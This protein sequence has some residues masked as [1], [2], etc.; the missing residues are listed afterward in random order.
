MTYFDWLVY[1]ISP[2][3]HMRERYSELL[4][5]LYSTEF[6][7]ALP[8][9]INRAKDGLDL[10]RQYEQETGEGADVFG[11]CTCLEM[12]I[13]LAIRCENELMYDPDFGDRTDQ[14]FWIMIDNL[15]LDQF[16]NDEF[17]KDEVDY[18]LNRFMNREYGIHGEFCMFPGTESVKNLKKME[19]A[20]QINY[21]VK[22]IL[23]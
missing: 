14:W 21:Y 5:A 16:E 22:L 12:M 10:R 19:L 6:F 17:D 9:D 23:C 4:F 7:W 1:Q 18:I 2:D 8:R 20:Y 15:G 3:Y 13:A 11:P